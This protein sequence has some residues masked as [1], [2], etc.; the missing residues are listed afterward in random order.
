MS[1][2]ESGFESRLFAIARHFTLMGNGVQIITSDSNHFSS[3]PQFDSTYNFSSIDR[4]RLGVIKTLKYSR[5]VSLKRVLSWI[6]FELKLFFHPKKWIQRPDVIIVSSLSLLTILNGLYYRWKYSSRLVFEVRDIWPLVLVEEGGYSSIHPMVQVLGR[7]E[8]IGYAKSD[9]IIGTM[10]NLHEHISTLINKPFRFG[11]I[12][13]GI[14]DYAI[15]SNESQSYQSES[16]EP[17]DRKLVIGYAGSIG[18][19]NGL[20]SFINVILRLKSFTSIHF[21]LLGDG[22]FREKYREQLRDCPNVI[23][24]D[25]VTKKEVPQF[26]AQCDIVYFSSLNSRVWKYGW[27]PNKIIDYMSAG[28]PILASYSGY[29]SMI[30]EANC[31][32]IVPAEEEDA[33]YH[34]I[35]EIAKMNSADLIQK[36][37]NGRTWLFANRRWS[38]LASEYIKLIQSIP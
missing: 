36:G 18:L 32:F 37:Q 31:G 33:L 20:D 1:S 28:K 19:S 4:I 8:K 17:R 6:D 22:E 24:L 21:K 5:S 38:S 29:V 34:Q 26:L 9:L 35:L 13:F 23:F 3:Y 14:D 15:Q 11:C 7:I 30:N 10:P 25:K 12:P 27:S 2:S 16:D